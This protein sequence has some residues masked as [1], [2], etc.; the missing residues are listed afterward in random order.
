WR[1]LMRDEA[2]AR[3]LAGCFEH[4]LVDE[5]QDVNSL[6]VEIVAAVKRAGGGG[7]SAVGDDFQAIYGFRAS[8]PR[9]IVE[10]PAQFPDAHTVVLERSYRSTPA[11]LAV[12]NAGSA[13]DRDAVSRRLWSELEGGIA[14]EL[15]FPHDEAA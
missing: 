5:Y 8:N 13:Q 6:Q 12:A 2:T 15:V 11:I 9:H 3:S 4:V 14:P 7:L 10:F 1:A